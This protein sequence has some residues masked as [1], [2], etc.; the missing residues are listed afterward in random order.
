MRVNR[1]AKIQTRLPFRLAG[2]WFES[3]D[4]LQFEPCDLHHV[5]SF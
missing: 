3:Q 1:A 4:A 5:G 2:I